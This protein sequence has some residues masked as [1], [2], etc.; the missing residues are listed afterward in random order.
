MNHFLEYLVP[1]FLYSNR[2]SYFYCLLLFVLPLRF[3]LRTYCLEGN[4]SNPIELWEHVKGFYIY[5][6]DNKIIFYSWKITLNSLIVLLHGT[7]RGL[8]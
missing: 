8:S 1:V 6:L 5:R 3:E 2:I 7:K 4:Y